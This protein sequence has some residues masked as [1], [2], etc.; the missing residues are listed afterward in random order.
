MVHGLGIATCNVGDR[1]R[2]SVASGDT[3]V[4][5]LGNTQIVSEGH[6]IVKIRVAGR[7]RRSRKTF[8]YIQLTRDQFQVVLPISPFSLFVSKIP[9]FFGYRLQYEEVGCSRY[10]VNNAIAVV[11]G[12]LPHVKRFHFKSQKEIVRFCT[13]EDSL[14]DSR[15]N[16]RWSG[17]AL[18]RD[19][20]IDV[21]GKLHF[22]ALEKAV[23]ELSRGNLSLQ[24]EAAGQAQEPQK[25]HV[26]LWSRW[27]GHWECVY[28]QPEP[29]DFDLE[30]GWY[31]IDH[32]SHPMPGVTFK[33]I[34]SEEDNFNLPS[35]EVLRV[36]ANPDS[37]LQY[38]RFH[39][40][41]PQADLA[42]CHRFPRSVES[43]AASST[44]PAQ[45]VGD[46]VDDTIPFDDGMS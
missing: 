36:V 33:K 43:V 37:D 19:E 25:S 32:L 31:V 35:G 8:R 28:F 14:I 11:L 46:N 24:R 10:A 7:L 15:H 1:A 22:Q 34:A 41:I 3:H 23:V 16:F 13:H 5:H 17:D 21:D 18:T 26:L 38:D 40:P 27:G 2:I 6:Y 29:N 12:H 42:R 44:L 39:Q 30:A 20:V 9:P 4:D 45:D